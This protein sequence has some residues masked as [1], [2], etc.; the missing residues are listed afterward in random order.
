MSRLL[1]E[2]KKINLIF[3]ELWPFEDL[4]ILKLSVVYL[5]NYLS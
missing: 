5:K 3:P 2:L 4:G 1:I